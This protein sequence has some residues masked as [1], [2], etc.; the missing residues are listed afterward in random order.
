MPR[1]AE[2]KKKK[3]TGENTFV[4]PCELLKAERV[5]NVWRFFLFCFGDFFAFFSERQFC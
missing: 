4:S 1:R 2:K 5:K 3:R